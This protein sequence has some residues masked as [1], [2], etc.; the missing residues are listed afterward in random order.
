MSQSGYFSFNIPA[1]KILLI[2]LCVL[3]ISITGLSAFYLCHPYNELASWY[4]GLKN[5][6][7][8]RDVW[9]TDFFNSHT[10]ASGRRIAMGAIPV[11][12][13]L[14]ILM[15][16]EFRKPVAPVRVN[17]PWK[18]VLISA[19]LMGIAT[20]AG[21]WSFRLTEHG[22]DEMYSAVYC[23]GAHPFQTVSYYMDTNN[24]IFFNILNN[25]IF[26]TV[27]DK[28]FTGRIL[29]LVTY[30]LLTVTLYL[31]LKE[32]LKNRLIA[33]CIT[34]V[35]I[36]QFP[37]LG[38][39]VQNRGYEIYLYCQWLS[40]IFLFKYLETSS[41]R[42]LL[43]HLAANVIGL[44]T[45]PTY[46]YFLLTVLL[47]GGIFQL[48]TRRI[49]LRFWKYQSVSGIFVF[50]LYVPVFLF[51]GIGSVTSN[52]HVKPTSWFV[53][54]LTGNFRSFIHECFWDYEPSRLAFY[55]V[56]CLLPFLV[57][58]LRKD[59]KSKI[60]LIF[61]LAIWPGYMLVSIAMKRYG[62]MRNILAQ[63]NMTLFI[64]LISL[65]RCCQAAARTIKNEVLAKP[66]FSLMAALLLA[67]FI[68]FFPSHIDY[69][70]YLISTREHNMTVKNELKVFPKSASI[71]CPN[72]AFVWYYFG[73][74]EPL[75]MV[76]HAKG[77]E[78]FI[79]LHHRDTYAIPA[80][81][82]L[83][84]SVSFYKIYKNS[85]SRL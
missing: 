54:D 71:V 19:L 45:I 34:L 9:Q 55:I 25:L 62:F 14:C 41:R 58:A 6:I 13:V 12:I 17:V 83:Y 43:M 23:A 42:Y 50:L 51:S 79:I 28:L 76:T 3:A 73:T 53:L 40:F 48:Y 82:K 60:L 2:I 70:L 21:I 22:A 67:H 52:K 61:Y 49:D 26:H 85:H 64:V 31:W 15:I 69:S 72:F 68:R 46:L 18:D 24:H 80:E 5:D 56:L 81:Y 38:F 4:L 57:F 63:E 47:T 27:T 29:S 36:L 37:V 20:V 65:Y 11:C 33:L 78:D 35:L 75:H 16:L 1:Y 84:K 44:Y 8:F 77:D 32:L 59:R 39:A 10:Y 7:A 66:A 74:K 30:L